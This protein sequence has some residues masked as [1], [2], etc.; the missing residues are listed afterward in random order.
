MM[1]RPRNPHPGRSTSVW[2]PGYVVQWFEEH[3]NPRPQR[4]LVNYV[5]DQ[6]DGGESKVIREEINDLQL[7]I[8]AL[9][10]KLHFAEERERRV[11]SKRGSQ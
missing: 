5:D 10:K 4:V 1:P 7:R 2:M 8:E 6:L 9:D 11:S 3:L